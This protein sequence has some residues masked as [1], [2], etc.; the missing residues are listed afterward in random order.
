ME[1]IQLPECSHSSHLMKTA[2]KAGSSAMDH[3]V[4]WA[5]T[6][7]SWCQP[8]TW[9]NNYHWFLYFW[10]LPEEA[11]FI[12]IFLTESTAIISQTSISKEWY[13][14]WEWDLDDKEFNRCHIKLFVSLI[15]LYLVNREVY[16][17]FLCFALFICFLSSLQGL[18]FPYSLFFKNIFLVV[19]H[20]C[21]AVTYFDSF[22]WGLSQNNL[23]C[24]TG[25]L[26]H[27]C[28][29]N[30]WCIPQWP[31]YRTLGLSNQCCYCRDTVHSQ[32]QGCWGFCRTH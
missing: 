17:W 24:R 6:E 27:G 1:S 16:L 2:G 19:K 15:Y 13:S 5:L 25:S 26:V 30:T 12:F 10:F 29:V 3:L 22:D 31:C 20:S 18:A 8:A 7:L 21:S 4:N 28:C 9:I 32:G 14:V 11:E 23:V